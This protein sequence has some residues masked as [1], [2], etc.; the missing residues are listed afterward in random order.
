MST[1]ILDLTAF[2]DEGNPEPI[3]DTVN[4]LANVFTTALREAQSKSKNRREVW[5][6]SGA[7]GQAFHLQAKA[8][9]LFVKAMAGTITEADLD[10]AYDCLNYGGFLIDRVLAGDLNGTWPWDGTDPHVPPTYQ[11]EE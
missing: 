6:E 1:V 5:K 3:A 10:D 11:K 2:D 7:R 4:M 9:R 8:E